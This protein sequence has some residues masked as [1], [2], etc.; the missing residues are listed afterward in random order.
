[1]QSLSFKD[2]PEQYKIMKHQIKQKT[3]QKIY[4]KFTYLYFLSIHINDIFGIKLFLLNYLKKFKFITYQIFNLP[5]S[6][7]SVDFYVDIT[8]CFEGQCLIIEQI[9]HKII[10]EVISNL[11]NQVSM[12]NTNSSDPNINEEIQNFNNYFLKCFKNKFIKITIS[13]IVCYLIRRFFYPTS[14]FKNPSFFIFDQNQ[15]TNEDETKIKINDFFLSDKNLENNVAYDQL[16]EIIKESYLNNNNDKCIHYLVFKE[17]DFICLRTLASKDC[18]SFILAFHIESCYIFMIKKV[19]NQ[20]IEHEI[21][22]CKHYSHRCLVHFYG[23][24]MEHKEIVGFVYEF[25]CNNS[26]FSIESKQINEVLALMTI[27]RIYQGIDYLHSHN[28]VHRDL[29]P[30]NILF[31]HDFL[32]YI[33]DFETIRPL[34]N[35]SIMTFDFGNYLYSSPEQ[36]QG[37]QIT[38]K[39]DIYS[40]G[41]IVYFIINKKHAKKNDEL[42]EKFDDMSHV[43]P[44]MINISYYFETLYEL[45]VLPEPDERPTNEDIKNHI[46]F[47]GNSFVYLKDYFIE[48][49]D[50]IDRSLIIQ[51]I[52]ESIM[53]Q[54]DKPECQ[55]DVF[56]IRFL[57]LSLCRPNIDYNPLLNI[58][59]LYMKGIYVKKDHSKAIQIYKFA[60]QFKNSYSMVEL[61][62]YYLKGIGGITNFSI[63]K[64]YYELAAEENNSTAIMNLAIMYQKGIGMSKDYLKAK[65]YYERAA[66][67]NNPIAIYNIGVFYEQGLGVDQNY[68]KAKEYYK[69][70]AKLNYSE[71]FV[72]LGNLYFHGNEVKRDYLKAIKYYELSSELN[73]AIGL[74]CLGNIYFY[75]YGIK[76]D[77]EVA[78]YYFEKAAKL[79]NT[80]AIFNLGMIYFYGYGVK[81]DY[82]RAKQFFEIGAKEKHTR[83]LLF[84]GICYYTGRGVEVDF[85]KCKNYLE[86]ILD[87]D[88]FACLLLGNIYQY[89]KGVERDICSAIKYYKMAAKQNNSNAF[90]N[91]GR[92]YENGFD[93]TRDYSRAKY[94]FEKA[95]KLNNSDAFYC[96][97]NMY[98]NGHGLEQ[99]YLKA[100]E[101]WEISANKSNSNAL[102]SLGHLYF[103]GYGVKKDYLKAKYYYE[104]SAKQNNSYAYFNLGSL[105]YKGL[106]VEQNIR[107]AI[108]NYELSAQLYNPS[109]LFYLGEIYSSGELVDSDILKGIMNLTKCYQ[110]KSFLDI[111][112]NFGENILSYNRQYNKFQYRAIND[113]G[114]IF[115][116]HINNVEYAGEFVKIAALNEYPFGQNNF[117]LFNQF[118]YN[119][120]GDAEYMY[121]RAS[122]H[123]FALAEYNLGYFYEK[124]NKV[125][126]SIKYYIK[127]SEHEN[128]PLIFHNHQHEDKRLEISKKFIICYTNIKLFYYFFTIPDYKEAKKYFIKAFNMQNSHESFSYP[129]HFHFDQNKSKDIFSYLSSYIFNFPLFDLINQPHLNKDIKSKL[130][131]EII[132]MNP[133]QNEK[134]KE[135]KLNKT[136]VVHEIEKYKEKDRIKKYENSTVTSNVVN[137]LEDKSFSD[138]F[139]RQNNLLRNEQINLPGDQIIFDS[140]DELIDYIIKNKE[141]QVLFINEIRKITNMMEI[142]LYTPPYSILFGRISIEKKKTNL[143]TKQK[144]IN[145]IFYEGFGIEI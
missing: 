45:C 20:N 104:L 118:Y 52:H 131:N 44:S 9:Q 135:K 68:L 7:E 134:D 136:N 27:N 54:K 55:R 105:Y 48:F 85:L 145:E 19:S 50:K 61:G 84:L 143:E 64:K 144:P 133:T 8:I 35:N 47:E 78:R 97:G 123:N 125:K 33:S 3:I 67:E 114:L 66:K 13:P 120:I 1:M 95:S 31:D 16:T 124:A 89:G 25:I 28:L 72:N 79:N 93:V 128:E 23:F 57:Y 102:F 86:L 26:L 24:L 137:C 103:N 127:A 83:S 37:K 129:F 80:M 36:I 99:S 2:I 87:K 110:I 69:M 18:K 90:I 43:S 59:K 121:K 32:P 126:K 21:N 117:G 40:F 34:G 100:K 101:Y 30:F 81:K 142:I 141:I 56:F 109:A 116:L 63:A 65:E 60:A 11:E 46:I 29:S 91:L 4:S 14:Y 49:K 76:P 75:G 94:Y 113:I 42:A 115:L 6:N 119:K 5:T 139:K 70:A 140:P 77:Y 107:K 122:K 88:S 58:A 96:L 53:I 132:K 112:S 82:S 111:N 138:E 62:D 92:I 73:N 74:L 98:Y 71:A 38:Y 15:S 108:K 17:N 130:A 12:I 22:F 51:F 10:Q 106:G 39:T 41:L